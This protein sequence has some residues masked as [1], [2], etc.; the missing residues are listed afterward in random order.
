L[1]RPSRQPQQ[2]LLMTFYS[3]PSMKKGVL[4]LLCMM[5]LILAAGCAQQYVEPVDGKDA[6][7]HVIKSEKVQDPELEPEEPAEDTRQEDVDDT[8][9]PAEKPV[10]KYTSPSD[11]GARYTEAEPEPS[12]EEKDNCGCSFTW[13][14]LCGRDGKTYINKCIYQCFG[15]SLDDIKTN[16]QCPKK[17]G[18]VKIWSDDVEID[19]D[20]DKWNGGYCWRQMWQ[21]S[22]I[23]YCENLIVNGRVNEEPS[24]VLGNWLDEEHMA[25]D[26]EG[27]ADSSSIHIKTGDQV[28]NEEYIFEAQPVFEEGTYRFSFWARE[29]VASNNDWKVR[30]VLKDWWESKPRPVDVQGCYE[31]MTEVNA[32]EVHIESPPNNWHHYHYEFSVPLDMEQWDSQSRVSSDCEFEWDMVPHG[33]G[34]TVT[35]PTIGEAW[36]D[37]FSLEKME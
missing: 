4:A 19:Y 15:N 8:P 28:K 30:L 31:L 20:T 26:R 16:S 27:R 29:D 7:K 14:P 17:Q 36:F 6:D 24:P 33:Y 32:N 12:S 37:D 25:Q 22:G 34:I 35:G 2:D 9:E 1:N 23:R 18:P 10:S 3:P 11:S 5:V 13:D 21:E